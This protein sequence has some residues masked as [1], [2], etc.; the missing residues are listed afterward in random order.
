[1]RYRLH[2][3]WA[4]LTVGGMAA[5]V[6]GAQYPAQ[7]AAKVDPALDAQFCL[8]SDG[9]APF[10]VVLQEQADLA[11]AA[12]LLTKNAKGAFVVAALRE[13]ATRTQKPLVTQLRE[14]GVVCRP[15]W[16]VNAVWGRGDATTVAKMASRDEVRGVVADQALASQLPK[17]DVIQPMQTTGV[18]WG[19]AKIHAPEVWA[20]GITGQG[21]VVGGQ[22]TG[23]AWDHPALKHAY[24]GWDG[25]NADHNYNWHDAIHVADTNASASA[26]PWDDDRHGTHTM[27]TMVGLDGANQI[28]AAPGARWIGCRNM[29]G[30]Y[31][32][33]SRYLECFEWF[34]A[35][36]DLAGLN[37]DPAKAPDVMNNSWIYAS[38]EG[39]T[40][41]DM[42]RPAVEACRAAG[43]VVVAS[44]GNSGPGAGSV[45]DPPAIYAASFTAGATDVNDDIAGFSSRGPVTSDGSGRRKP[46]VSAPGVSVR[47]SIPGGG[48]AS[49]SGTSMAG[50]H[51]VG[52]VALV[53]SA[54]PAL[55]GQVDK[56]ETLLERTALP[57]SPAPDNTYGWGRINALAAVG[58][59]DTDG[60]GMPD[61]WETIFGL[62]PTNATDAADD[63]DKDGMTTWQEW[64]CNTDPTMPSSVLRIDGMA[65]SPGGGASITWRSRQDG[66]R[67]PQSYVVLCGDS[68]EKPLSQ[69][70]VALSNVPP[71]GDWTTITVPGLTN[72]HPA[73]FYRIAVQSTNGYV[74]SGEWK[75]IPH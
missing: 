63:P 40:N 14:A 28:G 60:D 6:V 58:L 52:A 69:W 25:T 50:P 32:T 1:M 5:A 37:P 31:G 75:A 21:V 3:V 74:L 33:Y 24:R 36:T 64:M 71:A 18:E 61:W 53:L 44:A 27:G 65:L 57:R 11:P 42:L 70:T 45:S 22:D 16:I 49:L 46:D 56:V 17:P 2:V 4:V 67:E 38:I 73:L 59:G 20:L 55:K 35:P 47:S 43:I 12:R 8:S 19:I 30:G 23:Y 51:V 62:N 41:V 26:A 13:T 54:H 29:A 10:F 66:F 34:L 48:Y 39:C 72:G 7:I 15:Y 68:P 9:C